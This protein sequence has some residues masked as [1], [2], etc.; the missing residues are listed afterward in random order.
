MTVTWSPSL[1]TS[2]LFFGIVNPLSSVLLVDVML[3]GPRA[4]FYSL[5]VILFPSI[6]SL[7]ALVLCDPAAWPAED[8]YPTKLKSIAHVLSV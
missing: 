2:Q 5:P 1:S 8:K 3:A 7:Y 4:V 6:Y